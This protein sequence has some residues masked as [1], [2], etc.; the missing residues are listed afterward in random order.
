VDKIKF[1]CSGCGK[2]VNAPATM[3]GKSAKCPSCGRTITIPIPAPA[4][5]TQRAAPPPVLPPR[6][7]ATLDSLRSGTEESQLAALDDL[8]LDLPQEYLPAV[9]SAV[10]QAVGASSNSVQ[11]QAAII[12]VKL[13]DETDPPVSILFANLS[14]PPRGQ[15]N[16]VKCQAL[17]GLSYVKGRV[18][19]I[20]KLVNVAEHDKTPAMRQ[21]ALLALAGTGHEV[22]KLFL[23]HQTRHG[24]KAASF[25]LAQIDRAGSEGLRTA[26]LDGCVAQSAPAA[27]H[28]SHAPV[29]SSPAAE[30]EEPPEPVVAEAIEE[31]EGDAASL[32]ERE[33]QVF[34]MFRSAA[35]E[36]QAVEQAERQRHA[37][38]EQVKR[39]EMEESCAEAGRLVPGVPYTLSQSFL[40][41]WGLAPSE[42][43]V[44]P[45][46]VHGTTR[47]EFSRALGN[48][49]R[50]VQ[51]K[52]KAIESLS[53]IIKVICG[54]AVVLFFILL[55]NHAGFAV[56]FWVSVI[57]AGLGSG[58]AISAGS[59][60][61]HSLHKAVKTAERIRD[62]WREAA[63]AY[64]DAEV[65]KSSEQSSQVLARQLE[66]W[67]HSL[68]KIQREE[69]AIVS[70]GNALAPQWQDPVW[71]QWKPSAKKP[72]GVRV[73][74]YFL[75]AKLPSGGNASV[76]V[77]AILS[78]PGDRCLLLKAED[79]TIA[80]SPTAPGSHGNTGSDGQHDSARRKRHRQ[81][82]RIED[83]DDDDDDEF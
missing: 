50:V 68:S 9:R 57:A 80:K 70:L 74:N 15:E 69:R 8:P 39:K 43:S 55:G 32:T 64:Y 33:R 21:R 65:G 52:A 5:T 10:L 11:F 71:E 42:H 13:G 19:V 24:N 60:M 76:V 73:G 56:S 67:K 28:G 4:T 46:S 25:A 53:T 82:R 2:A 36:Y 77:P 47:T 29:D 66:S 49:T 83:F 6:L 7:K 48:C 17:Y 81:A 62:R 79:N 14:S 30:D 12:L 35:R 58:L 23:D 26:I 1:Q 75:R 20:D 31:P 78:F 27:Q 72:S 34:A 51:E 16:S 40:V 41:R 22:A 18:D 61:C 37:A 38:F 44:H 3:A 54:C 45:G 63:Q 59:G